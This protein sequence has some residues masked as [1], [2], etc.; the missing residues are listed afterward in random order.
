[1][2]KSLFTLKVTHVYDTEPTKY[3]VHTYMNVC[4]RARVGVYANE[5]L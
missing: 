5:T 3:Y 2:K 1:M 4:G